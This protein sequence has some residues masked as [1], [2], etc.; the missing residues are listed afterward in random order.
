VN[1]FCGNEITLKIM[2]IET[3]PLLAHVEIQVEDVT[4]E[5]KLTQAM[6]SLLKLTQTV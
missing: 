6:V 1:N 5:N 2:T 4:D 3:N